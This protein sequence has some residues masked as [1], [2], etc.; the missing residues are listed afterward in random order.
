MASDKPEKAASKPHPNPLA[1]AEAQLP[2]KQLKIESTSKRLS[3]LPSR[4][5][6][7]WGWG[8]R[9]PGLLSLALGRMRWLQEKER[10]TH[11]FY[12]SLPGTGVT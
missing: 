12:S 2:E 8:R 5:P 7:R 9:D 1:P 10:G 4:G 6:V 3:G 11:K